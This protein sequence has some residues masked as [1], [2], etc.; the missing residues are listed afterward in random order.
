MMLQF[1]DIFQYGITDFFTNLLIYGI[2][3][4]P[5]FLL[6]WVIYKAQLKHRRIQEKQRS[7]KQILWHEIKYSISTLFIFMVV[8]VALYVAQMNGFT[9]IYD[10]VSDYGWAYFVF[11]IV[12]MIV[13]HDTWF[14]WTHRLMHHPKLYKYIHKVHHQ[15][16]DPSPFAAFSFHPLEALVE[17]GAYI[18]FS[19]LFPVHL[20]ALIGWQL[21]QMLLNVI[22]HLGYEIYPNGFN[23]H[24][25]FK[26]K[27]PSTHHNLHHSHFSGNYGLYFT[28]WDKWCKTEFK[29]YHQK[30]ESVQK[31]ISEHKKIALIFIAVTFTTIAKAQQFEL[32]PSIG[33]GK[34]YIIES[35][36]EKK[37]LNIGYSPVFSMALKYKSTVES[38]W[39]LLLSIQHF[40]ARVKGITK[41]SQTP[42]DGFIGNTS[43]LI[44]TEKEKTL[45]KNPKWAFINGY[46]LGLSAENYVFKS[47][48]QPRRNVYLSALL[49]AGFS[50]KINDKVSIAITDGLLITDFIKGVHYLTGN[51]QGQS[52]GE[53]ISENLVLTFKIKL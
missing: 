17:A 46:G 43:F 3:V 20:M 10:K 31:R 23:T 14:Y 19:F 29:D 12:L 22:G 6:F 26:F 24:W 40:E 38:K 27:T 51:W 49:Y 18:I 53:D 41:I 33:Y 44:I 42:V 35:I 28:W 2:M 48:A 47:E 13:L 52:A 5:F 11:S 50:R 32:M 39:G 30:F 8:D 1:K 25:L 45:K 9:Q 21:L 36:E 34:P 15:S 37:D 4:V 7:T 16:T